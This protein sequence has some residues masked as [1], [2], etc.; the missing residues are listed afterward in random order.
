MSQHLKH[1]VFYRTNRS[2]KI[3]KVVR[4]H[5]LR[6]D[7]LCG[8]KACSQCSSL[9][10]MV[11]DEQPRSKTK[12]FPEDH[13]I[14]LDTNAVLDQIDALEDPYLTNIVILQT[15]LE[16]VKHRSATVYKR[17]KEII[18]DK[19][20]K[21]YVFVNEHRLE[22]YVE[23]ENGESANDR[24]DRAIRVAAKWYEDHLM[25]VKSVLLSDDADNRLK[26]FQFGITALS[27]S[28]YAEGTDNVT[29]LERVSS[30]R[31]SQMKNEDETKDYTA[32]Y[33][34]ASIRQGLK[35]GNLVQGVYFASRDNIL[36][37]TVKT[38]QNDILLQGRGS[39]NRA[40]D[41]DTVAVEILPESEWKAPS[42]LVIDSEDVD[43]I[44]ED[45][46]AEKQMTG[47]VVG[48]INR[49]IVQY[50]GILQLSPVHG[51]TRHLFVPAKKQVPKVRIETRQG[52]RLS[53]ERIVVAIDAWPKDSRYPQ[54]HFVRALGPI[55]SKEAENEV[56]L[57]EH[58]IPCANFSEAVLA[59]LPD[60]NCTIKEEEIKRRVDL[61]DKVICSV[62]PPGCTDIDDALHCI[63]LPNGNFEVGV[64]IA[65]V[66]HYIRPGTALDKEAALRS[67]TVYLT[68]KRIDMIPALLSSNLCSLQGGE[69]RL[70]FSCVWELTPDAKIVS[71]KVH[72]SVIKSKAALTYAA[73]QAIIDDIKD[74]TEVAESLRGLNFLAKKLKNE[75]IKNGALCL[76]SSEI[77][78][79]VD[80][81]TNDPVDVV[82]KKLM[83]T[84]SM[85]EEF[86]LLA[87]ISTAKIIWKEFPEC[88]LLRRHPEPPPS[89]FEPLVKAALQQGF[90][91][92]VS[93][94]KAL[95]ESLDLAVKEDNSYF[96]VM[97]R[98]V[99]TRCMMQAVYFCSGIL[100][101]K[102]FFHYGLATPI[103]TH[104][105]SPIRR[106]SD[107]IVHR[108]LAAHIGADTTY[109]DLLNKKKLDELCKNMNYRKRMAQYASRASVALHTRI[110][111][112]KKVENEEGYILFVKKNALQILIPKYGLEGN[113]LLTSKDKKTPS[114]FVFNS[115]D[116]TQRAGDVVFHPFDRVIV[117]LSV[118]TS[119]VQHEKLQMILVEPHIPGFSI[120]N[121]EDLVPG[122][123]EGF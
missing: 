68:D 97:L 109:T 8:S 36:E 115:E 40:I 9:S 20:R 42:N 44:A 48:I 119:N 111:F 39:I 55:G 16:E 121:T 94:G 70:A 15:V 51:H 118:D 54:G 122:E 110:F 78:F 27:L 58:D 43:E 46:N 6:D 72:K 80:T 102:D 99:T 90:E 85:V 114:P 112:R 103:Y 96:N 91:L 101:E 92:D 11:L 34:L 47:K 35:T 93:S 71:T 63:K 66:S 14:F 4:E 108:L 117:Q 3:L 113:V 38:E 41:G 59:D 98:I 89:N 1:K 5:Y 21:I 10:E 37:G 28:D 57:L 31:W 33:P 56:L 95:A 65:D 100:P 61:R 116:H 105:T 73:A 24:N 88:A 120:T 26:S 53:K 64:H 7:I 123:G 87:N 29:L 25:T 107:I 32:H 30:K 2:N 62:D 77:R 74:T 83:E 52:E 86:M 50:C 82:A 104:F 76:A 45:D 49:K 84:N 19:S 12:A 60:A 13:Y 106:Y 23:R 79:H 22:T 67:T 75:R 18:G 69:E 17:L 81:E